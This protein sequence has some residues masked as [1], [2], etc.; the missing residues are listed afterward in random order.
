MKLSA[1]GINPQM[2]KRFAEKGIDSVENLIMYL[3]RKYYD[4]SKETGILPETE[5]SSVVIKIESVKSYNKKTP[6]VLVR[7][8]VASTGEA[9]SVMFFNQDWVKNKIAPYVGRYAYAAGKISYNPDF[10]NYTINSPLVFDVNVSA[11]KR[12]YPVYSKIKGVS[13]NYLAEKLKLAI[14]NATAMA[15]PCPYKIV[16][17]Y[18]LLSIRETIHMLHFPQTMEQVTR[19]QDRILFNDLLYFALNIEANKR[20]GCKESPFVLK[21]TKPLKAFK[22]ILPFQL[23][24]DQEKVVD[25]LVDLASIGKRINSLIQGDVG[26]GKSIVA[27]LIMMMFAANGY[28]SVIMAPTQ[29]LA[30]QHYDEL[31]KIFDICGFNIVYLGSVSSMKAKD[32][33]KILSEIASGEAQI[34]VGTHSVISDSVKYDNLALTITDEEHKFGV[35]QRNALTER[36]KEGVHAITMSATP[37]PR[38]LAQIVYGDGL[39]LNTIHTSPNGRLPVR[40]GIATGRDKIYR[41]IT[42]E[43]KV[44][45]QAYVVCPM[46]DQND[47]M[48]GVKS[49]EEVYEEYSAAL[50]PLGVKVARLTGKDSKEFTEQTIDDFKNNRVQVLVAT[51]VIEVGVNVP[52]ATTIVISNAERFGLSTLHQLRGRVGRGNVQSYCVLETDSDQQKAKDRLQIMCETTDGFKIAEAD[53]KNRG[54]GDLLGTQ[55]AGEN[56]YVQ[57]MLANPEKYKLAQSAAKEILDNNLKC[58][59]LNA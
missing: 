59:Y 22:S 41:Y 35:V 58:S 1:I 14:D 45:H 30:K 34:I 53:L 32:R 46:I 17:E 6:L 51:T 48:E 36:S 21:D 40:T 39:Q 26:C 12:I 43:A 24:E 7:G 33:K 57:L 9:I 16:K 38:S 37:I 49:V 31:R 42:K 52:T 20:E 13:D 3:P 4:F 10:N 8:K 56:K 50:E 44:G 19:A 23:T 18:N 11:A 25:E 28:Q 27:F 55:Q 5:V 29:V 15:E 47:E 2:E 54:A